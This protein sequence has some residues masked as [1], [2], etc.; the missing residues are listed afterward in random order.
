MYLAGLKGL[1]TF[2]SSE[3]ECQMRGGSWRNLNPNNMS[4]NP[5]GY[6]TVDTTP[7][8]PPPPP[9]PVITVSVP[10]NV[11]TSVS[12]QISPNFVQQDKPVNSPVNAATKQET[13]TPA[14][15]VE[16]P[17]TSAGDAAYQALLDQLSEKLKTPASNYTPAY[18]GGSPATV[19][20]EAPAA[21][22]Q[23]GNMTTGDGLSKYLPFA[24]IGAALIYFVTNN[25]S[26]GNRANVRRS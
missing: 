23:V 18:S 20:N 17:Q 22:E 19:V 1:E 14:N 6:C 12:P 7:P 8:P 24:L 13:S 15:V 16:A 10:T 21:P 25:Q 26:G 4:L 2:T 3:R 9:A 5:I 11:Q